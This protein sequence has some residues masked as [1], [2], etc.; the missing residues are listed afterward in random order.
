MN[1]FSCDEKD[2]KFVMFSG[3]EDFQNT[4]NDDEEP[5]NIIDDSIVTKLQLQFRDT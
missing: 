4:E 1:I 2:K 3:I 5:L